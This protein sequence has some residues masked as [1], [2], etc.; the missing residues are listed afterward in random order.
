MVSQID[1]VISL[2][3]QSWVKVLQVNLKE[4]TSHCVQFYIDISGCVFTERVNTAE[5]IA[6]LVHHASSSHYI[7]LRGTI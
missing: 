5:G 7:D 6:F 4:F 3:T 2:D 1:S